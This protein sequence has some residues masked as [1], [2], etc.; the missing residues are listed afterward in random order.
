MSHV[1]PRLEQ[2][3]MSSAWMARALGLLY[4]CGGSLALVWTALP[5][6]Q[7]RRTT[8]LV[9]MAV[10]AV[11][12]GAGLTLPPAARLPRW[13]FHVVIAVIQVVISFGFV[14]AGP[15]HN[16]IRLFFAWATPYA[17]FFFGR[18]AAFAQGVWTGLCLGVSL[19][20]AGA[21]LV[22]GVGEWLMTMGTVAAVGTLVSI[23]ARRMRQAQDRLY[24]A[25]VHDPLTGLLNRRGFATALDSALAERDEY[26]GSVVVLL[27]D[28]DRFK[29]V[30]DTHGHHAG[31][32]LLVE[33]APRLVGAVRTSDFVARMGGDEFA[34][35]CHDAHGTLDLDALLRRLKDVW[36]EPARLEAG[37]L[38]VSG[39]V[40]V[41]CSEHVA[42]TAESLL[43]DADVALYRAKDIQ[44]GSAVIFDSSLRALLDREAEVDRALR[45]ALDRDELG[46][47][48]QAVVD[49]A[50]E[51]VVGAEALL[52]WTS[53]T[54]GPVP[55]SEFI[56]IAEDRGLIHDL[57]RWALEE[58]CRV[59]AGWRA[60]GEVSPLFRVALNVSGRQLVSGFVDEVTSTMERYDLPPH[61]IG[62]EITESVLIEDSPDVAACLADLARRG[63]ALLLDD[64]GTGFSSLSYLHRFPLT[65]IKVDKSFVDAVE[66]NPRQRA[67]VSA[68]LT[69][70]EALGLTVVAE[71]V[72]TAEVAR[73]LR[74]MGYS[75]AQGYLWARPVPAEEFPAVYAASVRS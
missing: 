52:R 2:V 38:P 4:L 36:A 73:V 32:Q 68:I 19:E 10:L 67:L 14:A 8:L 63:T 51:E 57:G 41:V 59:V 22:D 27:I 55:P 62:L 9:A 18:R 53:A 40:G 37:W 30:N 31:D 54:L 29:L 42:D 17:A 33:V 1:M 49:L 58:C 16:D 50:S 64:F 56:P 43:R 75:R 74:E 28:L 7:E 72:E 34:V 5:L 45:G 26:G 11:C 15:A 70:A 3:E 69:M 66:T 48:F 44:R 47:H 20:L 39:S 6:H 24:E 61:V 21:R 23:V 60:A 46:L 25:A 12:L 35:V 65:A 13:A 71:G